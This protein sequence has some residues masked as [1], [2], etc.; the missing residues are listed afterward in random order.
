MEGN[1]GHLNKI[2]KRYGEGRRTFR[3]WLLVQKDIEHEFAVR[4]EQRDEYGH[5][6]A[7]NSESILK[8]RIICGFVA[9]H[10]KGDLTDNAYFDEV[11]KAMTIYD[12][13]LRD[14]DIE[15]D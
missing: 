5:L 10:L 12:S 1:N 11:V 3:K 14:E 15:T 9:Q 7:V 6:A 13:D 4:M 2:F 8:N